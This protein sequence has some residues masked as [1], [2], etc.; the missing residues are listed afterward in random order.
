MGEDTGRGADGSKPG[1]ESMFAFL[2]KC[3]RVQKFRD[4]C[5][6]CDN[7][8]NCENCDICDN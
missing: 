8:D 6:N 5:I 2:M 7:C 1:L 3:I 4:N